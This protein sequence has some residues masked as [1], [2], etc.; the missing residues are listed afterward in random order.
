MTGNIEN[1]MLEFSIKLLG[2]LHSVMVG[3]LDWQ[4]ITS[5]FNSYWVP[6]TCGL[7]LN[8]SKA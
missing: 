4:T 7:V 5:E 8:L 6:Y 3:K 1:I 2:T